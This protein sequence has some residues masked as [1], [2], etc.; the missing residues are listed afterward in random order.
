MIER[1]DWWQV[2]VQIVRPQFP[3]GVGGH[4]VLLMVVAVSLIP[5]AIEVIKSR[6][7]KKAHAAG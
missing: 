7:A 2:L 4:D 6:R 1:L 5:I 3:T